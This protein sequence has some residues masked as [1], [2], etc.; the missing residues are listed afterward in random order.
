MLEIQNQ[1]QVQAAKQVSFKGYD[2]Y[3]YKTSPMDPD[4]FDREAMEAERDAKVDEINQSKQGLDDLADELE[5]SDNKIS[6]KTGK[7]LRVIATL[8]GLAGTFVMAKYSSKLV[9]ET[10]KNAA[11][12]PAAKTFTDSLKGMS[13][14]I[15]KAAE[16][17]KGYAEKALKNPTI[18]KDLDALKNTKFVQKVTEFAKNEKVANVLK[19]LKETLKSI[20]DIKINGKSIQ[21]GIENTMAAV[22][23]GSVLV[24][25]LAGRNNHKSNVEIASGI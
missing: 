3:A 23:T 5:N 14:P 17:L 13:K 1:P 22:T 9:I 18:K 11:K 7:G 2:D 4:Y 6:K 15:E 8:I 20:K 12:S 16:G 25:D 19:P 24:D 21:T 10:L